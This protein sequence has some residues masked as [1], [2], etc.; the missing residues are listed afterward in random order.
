MV[1]DNR[2]CI[3]FKLNYCNGGADDKRIGYLGVCSESV[4]DYN[5]KKAKRVWCK[6]DICDCK[7]Y[8][9]GE[10]SYEELENTEP[11]WESH[12]LIDWYASGGADERSRESRPISKIDD[13]IGSLCLLTTVKPNDNEENRIVFA[14]FI[15]GRTYIDEYGANFVIADKKYRLEFK[16]NETYKSKYWEI[17]KLNK[18]GS[19]R[20][21]SGLFRYFDNEEAIKF[22]KKAVEIKKGTSE[23]NFAKEF[24]NH[25]CKINNIKNFD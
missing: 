23:E 3:A 10:M 13:L 24:L 7:K 17:K 8:I 20:W 11:C 22:I 5:I 18:D 6:S 25:Y 4:I 19:K 14:M 12:L 1:K 2:N 9:D 21:G 16:P 15:I